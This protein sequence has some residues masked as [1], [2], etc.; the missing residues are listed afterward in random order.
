MKLP[1]SVAWL[2]T[3]SRFLD[4]RMEPIGFAC[5]RQTQPWSWGEVLEQFE[6]SLR[7][8]RIHVNWEKAGPV[9]VSADPDSLA[10]VF[11]NL[12]SNVEKYAASG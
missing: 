8:R 11:G 2:T 10:Q 6:M 3:C 4:P 7:D 5:R 9:H 12:L 1:G